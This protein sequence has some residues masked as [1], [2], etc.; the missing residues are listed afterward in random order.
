MKQ[1]TPMGKC[2]FEELN[3]KLS[4]KEYDNIVDFAVNLGVENAFIQED[5][6]ADHSFIP[7]FSSFTGV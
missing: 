1:Y 7:D 2:K 3:R 6:T 5:E 4:N